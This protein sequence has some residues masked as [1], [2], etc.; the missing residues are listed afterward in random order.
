MAVVVV[1]SVVDVATVTTVVAADMA[2]IVTTVA[3]DMAAAGTVI[4][5]D[6][7]AAAVDLA[8]VAVVAATTATRTVTWPAIA[9]MATDVVDVEVAVAADLLS[10]TTATDPVTLPATV[11]RA[12]DV[13]GT[14]CLART[15]LPLTII[16]HHIILKQPRKPSHFNAFPPQKIHTII[17]SQFQ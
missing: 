7:E 17:G 5:T 4:V 1:D 10:A 15:P 6:G 13:A 14:D 11:R 3:A 12:T 2:G 9:P 8:E 16:P